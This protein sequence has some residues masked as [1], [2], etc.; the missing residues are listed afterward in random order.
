MNSLNIAPGYDMLEVFRCIDKVQKGRKKHL[1]DEK[2]IKKLFA[3]METLKDAAGGVYV[4]YMTAFSVAGF[5]Y[6]RKC[7]HLTLSKNGGCISYQEAP[8]AR[9]GRAEHCK[10]TLFDPLKS[11]EEILKLIPG[12]TGVPARDSGRLLFIG[13]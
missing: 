3:L 5:L 7:F 6:K 9:F 8:V 11:Q 2:T 4:E 10:I 1:F 13:C 12:F